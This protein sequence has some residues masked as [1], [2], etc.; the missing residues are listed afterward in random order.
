MI[1]GA[2]HISLI[3][4][5]YLTANEETLLAEWRKYTE[6]RFPSHPETPA[7]WVLCSVPQPSES[8]AILCAVPLLLLQPAVPA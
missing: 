6:Q 1:L 8:P 5:E 7:F 4:F 3:W 2:L